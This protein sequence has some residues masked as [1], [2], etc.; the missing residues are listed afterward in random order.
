[1]ERLLRRRKC[2]RSQLDA[3]AQEAEGLLREPQLPSSQVSISIHRINAIYAH[4]TKIDESLVNETPEGLIEPET[5]DASNHG[6]KIV[7]LTSKLRFAIQNDPI[8]RRQAASQ[9]RSA[10]PTKA[11]P[12]DQ[13]CCGRCCTFPTADGLNTGPFNPG[14]QFGSSALNSAHAYEKLHLFA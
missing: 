1:M 8:S 7:T 5:F 14:V 2:L 6:D 12:R 10:T 3:I 11:L 4:I 9:T 13:D